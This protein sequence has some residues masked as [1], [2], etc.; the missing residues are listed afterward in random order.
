MNRYVKEVKRAKSRRSSSR[1]WTG[2][3]G[4]GGEHAAARRRRRASLLFAR[5]DVVGNDR[6][7]ELALA[8][9]AVY[10]ASGAALVVDVLEMGAVAQAG[11]VGE[12]RR[13][14]AV[15]AR[16]VSAVLETWTVPLQ[17]KGYETMHAQ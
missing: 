16:V 12:V 7:G 15:V 2:G 8:H 11:G 4:E 13:I 17:Q 6:E 10:T 5:G 1:T 3:E 9:G 14:R